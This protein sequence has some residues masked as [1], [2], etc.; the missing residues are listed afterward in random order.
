MTECFP[1][2]LYTYLSIV[3]HMLKTYQDALLSSKGHLFALYYNLCIIFSVCSL[4]LLI[5]HIVLNSYD[6]LGVA[7][8]DTK[9]VLE[10][11]EL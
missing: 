2:F 4:S 6:I 7:W 1:F 11:M 9:M 8:V 5:C 3:P 10:K